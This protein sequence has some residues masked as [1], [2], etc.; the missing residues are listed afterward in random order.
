MRA[1]HLVAQVVLSVLML[2]VLSGHVQAID[3]YVEGLSIHLED[4]PTEVRV[5]ETFSMRVKV[6]NQSGQA[7]KALLRTYLYSYTSEIAYPPADFSNI[8]LL[9]EGDWY[10][11]EISVN[12]GENENKVFTFSLTVR[13]DVQLV[14][15]SSGLAKLRTRIRRIENGA[16][17]NL[18]PPDNRYITLLPK[19]GPEGIVGMKFGVGA[20]VAAAIVISVATLQQ[21]STRDARK[22]AR[23]R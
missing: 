20:V 8:V 15:G 6:V 18:A 13:S 19:A 11:N 3:N 7:V 22:R 23:K 4:Y 21:R 9:N 2:V 5:G 17:V 10:P 14:P 12:L 16:T 1:A